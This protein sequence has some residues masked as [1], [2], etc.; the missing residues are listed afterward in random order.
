MG[1]GLDTLIP[2]LAKERLLR[3]GAG[4][5][6]TGEKDVHGVVDRRLRSGRVGTS[7]RVLADWHDGDILLAANLVFAKVTVLDV[8]QRLVNHSV[9]WSLALELEHHQSVVVT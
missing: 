9:R 5:G 4:P 1:G 8:P 3:L 2:S 7:V 6:Y